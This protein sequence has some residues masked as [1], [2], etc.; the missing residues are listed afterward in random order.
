MVAPP[1]A[2]S[3]PERLMTDTLPDSHPLRNFFRDSLEK[4]FRECKDL[5]SPAVACHLSDDVLCDFIHVD[6]IYR[7]KSTEGV[8]LEELPEMLEVSVA[9]EGPERRMEVDTYIGDFT[10]FMGG[11][12]PTSVGRNRW[13]TPQPMVSRVGK[14]FVRFEHPLEYYAAEGRNAYGRAAETAR[15]FAP[16]ARETYTLLAQRFDEYQDLLRRVKD[17]ISDD[18][19]FRQAED[20]LD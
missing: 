11:F 17:L 18:P 14:V 7:L 8:R 6:R 19:E 3:D 13:F 20:S 4:A 2:P 12:F 1:T 15:I 9:P 5:Y 10:L 16:D